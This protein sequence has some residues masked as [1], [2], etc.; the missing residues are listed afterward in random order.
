MVA[1]FSMKNG[2]GV[3]P[4]R[5]FLK[6]A[7]S[8]K[9]LDD[10]LTHTQFCRVCFGRA[11]QPGQVGQVIFGGVITTLINEYG[12]FWSKLANLAKLCRGRGGG[13]AERVD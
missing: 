8:E 10:N 6:T 7:C 5:Y 13:C 2:L 1:G 11:E 12:V 9:N 4:M 3:Q